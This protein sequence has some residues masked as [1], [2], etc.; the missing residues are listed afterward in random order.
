MS[1]DC[2][3]VSGSIHARE[4]IMRSITCIAAAITLLAIGIVVADAQTSN[5]SSSIRSNAVV[6]KKR[7]H[8]SGNST[9]RRQYQPV[10]ILKES[11]A[12]PTRQGPTYFVHKHLAG[13]KY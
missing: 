5:R 3:L 1:G 12:G 6:S 8:V 4:T 10:R 11:A 13:V 9:G 7:D 2:R